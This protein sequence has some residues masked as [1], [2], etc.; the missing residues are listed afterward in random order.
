MT[1]LEFLELGEISNSENPR[2]SENSGSD[3]IC[4]LISSANIIF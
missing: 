4:A 3:N 2:N 1:E